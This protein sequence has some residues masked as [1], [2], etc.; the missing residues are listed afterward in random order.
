MGFA[1]GMEGGGDNFP[2][3]GWCRDVS[4][5]IGDCGDIGTNPIL[6]SFKININ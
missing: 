4:L 1:A 5:K 2:E 6:S 3:F